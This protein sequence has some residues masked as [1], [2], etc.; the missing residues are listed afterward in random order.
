MNKQREN[1]NTR[2][3][4]NT[5]TF[6]SKKE[7]MA[8]ETK[9]KV[10]YTFEIIILKKKPVCSVSNY[11]NKRVSLNHHSTPSNM[12]PLM[13]PRFLDHER[14]AN[15]CLDRSLI[16]HKNCVGQYGKSR[17]GERDCGH[18]LK[19]KRKTYSKIWNSAALE[20]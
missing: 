12:R 13:S 15:A 16:S 2:A 18:A 3:H 8:T 14:E 6:S 19:E 11:D 17:R 5:Y 4:T 7:A 20:E 10:C 9:G 1:G